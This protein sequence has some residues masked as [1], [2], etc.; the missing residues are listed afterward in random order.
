M[1]EILEFIVNNVHFGIDV[2]EIQEIVSNK[3]ITYI[4]QKNKAILGCMMIRKDTYSVIDLKHILYNQNTKIN[5]N[6]FYILY[7]VNENKNA[8][9]VEEVIGIRKIHEIIEP[10]KLINA[11]NNSNITGIIKA[12]DIIISLLNFNKIITDLGD[13]K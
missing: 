10:P 8:L 11:S 7:S 2:S 5:K 6:I 13:N 9:A 3:D 4:P 12:D 1:Q